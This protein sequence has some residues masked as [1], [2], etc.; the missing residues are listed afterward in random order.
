MQGPAQEAV[1]VQP[2]NAGEP[3]DKRDVGPDSEHRHDAEIRLHNNISAKP[4]ADIDRVF[5][6]RSLGVI[7]CQ[8]L[9]KTS[10]ARDE[11]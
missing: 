4:A 7:G 2:Q 3:R 8:I 10:V 6:N 11:P 1:L 5:N 9:S